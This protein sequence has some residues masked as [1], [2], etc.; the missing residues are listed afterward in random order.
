MQTYKAR[1]T[2]ILT[3]GIVQLSSHQAMAHRLN[4]HRIGDDLYKI[5]RAIHFKKGEVFGHNAVLKG[6][7]VDLGRGKRR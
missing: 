4:L 2:I 7:A 3:R 5:V 6:G 1:E